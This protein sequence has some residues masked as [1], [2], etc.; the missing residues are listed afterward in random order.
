LLVSA[1]ALGITFLAPYIFGDAEMPAMKMAP[2][3]P[4]NS[5]P[6]LSSSEVLAMTDDEIDGSEYIELEEMILPELI[7]AASPVVMNEKYKIEKTVVENEFAKALE[8]KKIGSPILENITLPTIDDIVYSNVITFYVH[9]FLMVDYTAIY[10]DQLP[11]QNMVYSGVPANVEGS[12]EIQEVE[13]APKVVTQYVTYKQYLFDTQELFAANNFKSALKRYLHILS[14]YPQDL[15]A[16][17]YGGLC[18]YNLQQFDKAIEHFDKAAKHPYN[19]FRLDAEWYKAKAYFAS[20]EKIKSKELL[21]KIIDK[22]DYYAKQALDL[23]QKL[24]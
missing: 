5:T 15:N 12:D 16:H 20:G 1:L 18:Y 23:L 8:I 24:P 17:F 4:K 22:N 14:H 10:T 21:Q 19:T 3:K 13:E 11:V 7:I 9:K 2:S 6:H